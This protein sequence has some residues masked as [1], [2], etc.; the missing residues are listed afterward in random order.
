[1]LRISQEQADV[2]RQEAEADFN[3]RVLKHVRRDL[4]DPA[5]GLSDEDILRRARECA[6]LAGKHG[7]VTEKQLMCF[8]DTSILLGQGFDRDPNQKW[9]QTLLAST[10]LS[11]GDK[12]NLLLA[13]A[14]CVYSGKKDDACSKE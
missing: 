3:R 11:A 6:P 1:M 7:L 8:V 13:T 14:C 4:A 5:A 9:V 10:K 2:F 12:A